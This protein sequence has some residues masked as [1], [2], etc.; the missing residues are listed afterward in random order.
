MHH[1]LLRYIDEVARQGSIRKA[2]KVLNVASS[3]VNRQ[4]LKVEAEFKTRIFDRLPEGVELTAA[5][6]VVVE[7]CRRTLYD[8]RS[9]RA[10]IDDIRDLRSGHVHISTLD[11]MVFSFLPQVIDDF[12]QD[13]PGIS[14]TVATA[15]PEE[16]IAGVAKGMV[17]V[18][19][20]FTRD[21]HP[22]VRVVAEKPSPFGVIMR[23]DHP[24]ADR[25]YVTV[26]DCAAFP[27]V[28]TVDARGKTS[29]IDQEIDTAVLPLSAV[30][31]TNAL[32]MAKYAIKAGKGV[33]IYTK[34]GFLSEIAEGSLRFVPLADRVLSEY[35]IGAIISAHKN[36]ETS[37]HL[38]VS[39]IERHFRKVDFT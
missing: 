7:H 11:S 16:T 32:I 10:A 38:L 17:N 20:S 39:T 19:L 6:R 2:A 37:A 22:N 35:K 18:G 26:E 27:L 29:L 21:L 14:F 33:G 5:G 13:H 9:I 23:P 3:A 12:S 31:F 25:H 1:P 28:R 8:Y 24:L 4:I 15:G 34:V 36:I 30:F